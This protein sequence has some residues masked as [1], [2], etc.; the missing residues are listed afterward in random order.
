ME[1]GKAFDFVNSLDNMKEFI[2]ECVG[3]S[4]DHTHIQ[5][6]TGRAYRSQHIVVLLLAKMYY[7]SVLRM[8]EWIIRGRH[9]GGI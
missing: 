9:T 3:D 4:Q 6:F 2:W 5:R 1:Y 7:S 8:Y